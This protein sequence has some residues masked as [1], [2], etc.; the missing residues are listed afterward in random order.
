MLPFLKNIKKSGVAG[1]IIK[2]R[3]P[4]EKPEEASEE[5]SVKSHVKGLMS[6]I[7]SDDH[8]HAESCLREIFKAL[9]KEP[10]EEGE[11]KEPSPHSYEAQNEEAAD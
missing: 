11:H 1:L 3:T 8:E 5:S 7:K 2:N 9:D 6:A 10:H 4:D